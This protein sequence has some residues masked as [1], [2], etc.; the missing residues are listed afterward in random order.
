MDDKTEATRLRYKDCSELTGLGV[1]TLYALVS[2]RRIPHIRLSRRLVLFER[3][4][5]L[6][7]LAQHRVM[8]SGDDS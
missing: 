5:V 4:A 8:A 6:K 7:W 1:N 3:E 2:Q